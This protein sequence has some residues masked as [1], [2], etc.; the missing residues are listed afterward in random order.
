MRKNTMILILSQ[1]YVAFRSKVFRGLLVRDVWEIEWEMISVD[2]KNVA[3]R[4][5]IKAEY[6]AVCWLYMREI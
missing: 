3:S 4:T 5:Q 1:T 2:E 6:T